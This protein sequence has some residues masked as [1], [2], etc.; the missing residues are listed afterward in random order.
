MFEVSGQEFAKTAFTNQIINN[1]LS[2]A[3]IIHGPDGTGKSIF[4][5]YMAACILCTGHNKPCGLCPSCIKIKASNHP[6]F[7]V[8]S[9]D[10]KSIGV[11]DIRC[12]IED[13]N[14]KPYEGDKKVIL[15]K[16]AQ[17]ITLQG[18]NAML[19]TLEEPTISTTI[20]MLTDNI[21]AIID[22]I[23][24]R[25]QLLPFNRISQ[26][27][28]KEFLLNNEIDIERAELFSKLSDGIIGNALKFTNE[29]YINLRQQTINIACEC[30]KSNETPFQF[31]DY[32]IKNK[33]RINDILDIL[34]TWYRDIIV[35]KLT[36]NKDSIINMDY[37]N[38]L[39]E[40]SHLL[41][42]N[43]LSNNIEIINNTKV[44][45]KGYSNYQLTIEVM[46]LKFQEVV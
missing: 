27:L 17:D 5:R 9:K 10:K 28:V 38:L 46:L 25:A 13:I 19:K 7:K 35:I 36:N 23:K 43:R 45:L 24:S 40:Q 4:A 14:T 34:T 41:S 16:D 42:Y 26:N 3:Y 29:E 20:I 6:D 33:D 37:Y 11:D 30:S 8:V 22:T 15:I 32:F 1:K 12:L 44:K 18:Q 31:V 39:V 2:H 21:N